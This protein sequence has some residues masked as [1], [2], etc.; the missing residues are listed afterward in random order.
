MKNFL[1]VNDFTQDELLNILSR[2][3]KLKECW[4]NNN[5]PQS[6]KNH[7]IAIWCCGSGFRNRLAFD[8]GARAMGAE[9]FYIPGD[10]GVHEPIEDIGYYL[11]NWFT[12]LIIRT[13]IHENLVSVSNDSGLPTINART[14]YNHPC[15]IIG[16]L[17]YIMRRRGSIDEINVVFIG[18]VTNL[19]MS[20]FEAAQVLPISVTQVAPEQ[21]LLS[22]KE[23]AK[24]NNNAIG[25]IETNVY[26]NEIITKKV[27]LVYTDCW[28][29]DDDFSKIEK[30]FLPYQV[31]TNLLKKI[32]D[33]GFFLPCPP[34][35]RG[36]EVSKEVLEL[37]ICQNYAAKEFLLHSQNAIME[38]LVL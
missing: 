36:Q 13:N 4:D 22:K 8:I 17:Q 34:V 38:F 20:W 19:C 1:K 29:K 32:N 31:T 15:E 28:P 6:L 10:L 33:K 16:D 23:V 26:L 14:N 2:A 37:E 30:L 9:V 25:K 27:D 11:K 3:E 21:Y 12:M 24:F 35:T 7:R 5:I 18:E